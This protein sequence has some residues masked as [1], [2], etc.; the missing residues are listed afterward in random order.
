MTSQGK[1][2]GEIEIMA[3]LK[4]PWRYIL[5]LVQYEGLPIQWVDGRPTLLEADLERWEGG[6]Q[7]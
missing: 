1:F 6:R 7:K 3:E 4:A 5:A 2:V